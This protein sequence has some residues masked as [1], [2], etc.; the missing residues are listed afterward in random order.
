MRRFSSTG[1]LD[2]II[3]YLFVLAGATLFLYSSATYTDMS[4]IGAETELPIM[5]LDSHRQGSDDFVYYQFELQ[6]EKPF[7]LIEVIISNGIESKSFK[8]FEPD[9]NAVD[10][11]GNSLKDSIYLSQEASSEYSQS[12]AELRGRTII[13]THDT[14]EGNSRRE[15]SKNATEYFNQDDLNVLFVF[16][17]GTANVHYKFLNKEIMRAPLFP[18]GS[19][20]KS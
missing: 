8:Y 6:P 7:T 12:N 11:W 3:S 20:T 4:I 18:L 9:Y 19:L 17:E 13:L 2:I 14:L 10:I 1:F 5:F 15:D 16:K